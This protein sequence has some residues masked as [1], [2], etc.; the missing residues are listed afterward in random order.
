MSGVARPLGSL[1]LGAQQ[2]VAIA[3]AVQLDARVV[4]MDEPTSSLEQ[5]EVRDA[6]RR[7]PAGCATPAS[8]SLYVSHRLDELY[9]ICDDVTVLRDGAVVHTGELAELD[10]L[11]LVSLM[12]GRDMAQVRRRG[13][14]RVRRRTTPTRPSNPC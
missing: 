3:R 9:T 5:R 11:R 14:D 4:I 2:M 1:G 7:D 6:V 12:L 13:R 8:R 10:R